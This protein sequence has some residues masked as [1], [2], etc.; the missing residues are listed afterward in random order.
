MKHKRNK[1]YSK[2]GR[3]KNGMSIESKQGFADTESSRFSYANGDNIPS[4]SRA[5]QLAQVKLSEV[6]YDGNSITIGGNSYLSYKDVFLDA[7][8]VN[9]AID[10][11]GPSY[12]SWTFGSVARL[13]NSGEP[14]EDSASFQLFNENAVNI[15]S[16]FPFLTSIAGSTIK[17]LDAEV[18][19]EEYNFQLTPIVLETPGPEVLDSSGNVIT[20]RDRGAIDAKLLEI[21]NKLNQYDVVIKQA[22]STL[23]VVTGEYNSALAACDDDTNQD[24][25]P[26]TDAADLAQYIK[27]LRDAKQNAEQDLAL[28]DAVSA[29]VEDAL[30]GTLDTTNLSDFTEETQQLLTTIRDNALGTAQGVVDAQAVSDAADDISS[31]ITNLNA[32]LNNLGNDVVALEDTATA[33]DINSIIDELQSALAFQT[34]A[35]SFAEQFVESAQNEAEGLAADLADIENFVNDIA[36]NPDI[37]SDVTDQVSGILNTVSGLQNDL[38][39]S[40]DELSQ[41]YQAGAGGDLTALQTFVTNANQNASNLSTLQAQ[42]D[43]LASIYGNASDSELDSLSQLSNALAN[44][45]EDFDGTLQAAQDSLAEYTS[46]GTTEDFQNALDDAEEISQIMGLSDEFIS[47]DKLDIAINNLLNAN[48]TNSEIINQLITSLEEQLGEEVDVTTD[49][50]VQLVKNLIEDLNVALQQLEEG[51]TGSQADADTIAALTA[52]NGQLES[53]V[54]DLDSDL[55]YYEGILD[56]VEANVNN[57][58]STVGDLEQYLIDE[59]GYTPPIA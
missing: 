43:S 15:T 32:D 19:A 35:V 18:L 10:T 20:V 49:N 55:V 47:S 6:T 54:Q 37:P 17:L 45:V 39:S 33:E 53:L 21:N 58:G 11:S 1:N 57:L 13:V 14:S 29:A 16:E 42:L 27:D 36:N 34:S 56:Q 12:S 9:A 41:V 30:D 24:D 51:A 26:C 50:A 48:A 4:A 52:L 3:L 31:I 28:A 38:S 59:H 8:A 23:K 40:Q 46:L 25:A 44:G 22:D 7:L 2:G 5:T